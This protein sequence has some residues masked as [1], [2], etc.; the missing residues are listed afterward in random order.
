MEE[1]AQ[2]IDDVF[3]AI[4][5]DAE[6]PDLNESLVDLRNLRELLTPK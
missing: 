5:S 4:L 3:R 2:K 1:L 6:L